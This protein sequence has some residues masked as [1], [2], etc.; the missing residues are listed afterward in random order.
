LPLA[1]EAMRDNIASGQSYLPTVV[2]D[3]NGTPTTQLADQ[4]SRCGFSAAVATNL[5]TAHVAG[6]SRH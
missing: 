3:A 6:H 4:L 5:P 2:V 1:T